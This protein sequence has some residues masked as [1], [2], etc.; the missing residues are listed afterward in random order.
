[1]HS[2]TSKKQQPRKVIIPG[3]VSRKET[4]SQAGAFKIAVCSTCIIKRSSGEMMMDLA[5]KYGH[6][7]THF[8]P[9]CQN[10][11]IVETRWCY[12]KM[13]FASRRRIRLGTATL[14]FKT[15]SRKLSHAY[16]SPGSWASQI[17]KCLQAL[18][19]GDHL[20]VG[21]FDYAISCSNICFL[22]LDPNGAYIFVEPIRKKQWL[23]RQIR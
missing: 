23:K 14:D 6:S 10:I 11:D 13:E 20:K 2:F 19:N 8:P 21:Y 15:M 22:P 1:M 4:K 9:R 3:A 16:F 7:I 17:K 5:V 18:S 12:W